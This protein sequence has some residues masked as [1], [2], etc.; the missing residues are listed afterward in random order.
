MQKVSL[1]AWMY[2]EVK[3]QDKV[4]AN[5]DTPRWTR[6]K[7]NIKRSYVISILRSYDKYSKGGGY[8]GNKRPYEGNKTR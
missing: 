4:I 8:G 2:N 3:K 1:K 5:K 7:A 6:R